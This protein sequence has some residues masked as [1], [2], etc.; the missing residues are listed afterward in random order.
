[1]NPD[2]SW[3]CFVPVAVV[4]FPCVLPGR[5]GSRV[6]ASS[7]PARKPD[8]RVGGPLFYAQL[9]FLNAGKT[10]PSL[11]DQFEKPVKVGRRARRPGFPAQKN[12]ERVG[13]PCIPTR[14]GARDSTGGFF[15]EMNRLYSGGWLPGTPA[16][17]ACRHWRTVLGL[18]IPAHAVHLKLEQIPRIERQR[19]CLSSNRIPRPECKT[20]RR[21]DRA[22][23]NLFLTIRV[24]LLLTHIWHASLNVTSWAPRQLIDR[25]TWVLPI[26]ISEKSEK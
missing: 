17:R 25:Q 8:R 5:P 20:Y 12:P 18:I 21:G 4:S 2:R 9:G 26:S 24:R 3:R 22:L 7:L 1:M 6:C 16:A 11:A 13:G 23:A 15:R 10:K 14:S 19:P